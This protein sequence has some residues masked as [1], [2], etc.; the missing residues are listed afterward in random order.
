LVHKLVAD[1]RR[2]ISEHSDLKLPLAPWESAFGEKGRVYY[3]EER[4]RTLSCLETLRVQ[5]RLQEV[6]TSLVLQL[7]LSSWSLRH[8]LQLVR[9]RELLPFLKE[10]AQVAVNYGFGDLWYTERYS[11]LLEKLASVLHIY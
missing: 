7:V 6:S 1:W 2:L 10:S 11:G 8:R 5:E 3:S 4:Q 9:D